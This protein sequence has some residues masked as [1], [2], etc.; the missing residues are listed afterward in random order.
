[1]FGRAEIKRLQMH[2]RALLIESSMNRLTLLAEWQNVRDRT[3][4][5]NDTAHICRQFRPWL[6]LAAPLAGVLAAQAVRPTAGGILSRLLSA[7]K[8]IQ[9]LWSVWQGMDRSPSQADPKNPAA[10]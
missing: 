7:L 8:W 1:M 2:K 9:P 4:W 10:A 3:A 5:V 6:L